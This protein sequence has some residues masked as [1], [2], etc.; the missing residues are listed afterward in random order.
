MASNAL[1]GLKLGLEEVADLIRA[2]PPPRGGLSPDPA[3]TRSVTMACIVILCSHFERYLRAI[4]EGAT[5]LINV[6]RIEGDALP[7][8]FRLQHSQV[9]IDQLGRMEWPRRAD[10]LQQFVQADAWLWGQP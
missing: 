6:S 9:A 5:A 7:E 8:R 2:D 4:N 3:L 1:A 10:A